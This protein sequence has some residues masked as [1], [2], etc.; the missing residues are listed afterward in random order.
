MK[1]NKS[2]KN[3]SDKL[4]SPK[5]MSSESDKLFKCA[6]GP[7]IHI[8]GFMNI[9]ELNVFPLVNRMFYDMFFMNKN[10]KYNK[11]NFKF[12]K[13]DF[14]GKRTMNFCI[15]NKIIV[16]LRAKVK[17]LRY[18]IEQGA[19]VDLFKSLF[20]NDEK[21]YGIYMV[22]FLIK[23]IVKKFN[24]N[25]LEFIFS[26]IRIETS[27]LSF[28]MWFVEYCMSL[29]GFETFKWLI[30]TFNK[31]YNERLQLDTGDPGL[32]IKYINVTQDNVEMY[33]YI[34]ENVCLD[35][36]SK[37]DLLAKCF[38]FMTFENV[39]KYLI[40]NPNTDLW[41]ILMY[42][43]PYY[44]FDV[45]IKKLKLYI[46]VGF[47][48]GG[49]IFNSITT[50]SVLLNVIRKYGSNKK[51]VLKTLK[52]FNGINLDYVSKFISKISISIDYS[53]IYEEFYSI[54]TK[55]SFDLFKF[56]LTNKNIICEKPHTY[57]TML[58]CFIC[59]D[60]TVKTLRKFKYVVDN[61]F[62]MDQKSIEFLLG[63]QTIKN[64]LII[65]IDWLG[66]KQ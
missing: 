3:N 59:S 49:Q 25:I 4:G 34:L 10:F 29:G 39:E 66:R 28:Y 5:T 50:L 27:P 53:M 52:C 40:T 8:F 22:K 61:H 33:S 47:Q 18:L 11:D 9:D 7:L 14:L 12:D 26:I 1:Q 64:K 38:R 55:I 36:Q 42:A 24:E 37:N 56:L 23:S 54:C 19:N 6:N 20:S 45:F 32:S 15:K 21:I 31:N 46:D 16:P 35:Y 13:I 48:N 62:K 63:K 43:T 60:K 51:Y 58:K 2:E 30:K 41:S 17:F 44:S 65:L 57:F